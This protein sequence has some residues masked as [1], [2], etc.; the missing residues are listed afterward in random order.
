M[1]DENLNE[2]IH[3]IEELVHQTEALSDP[4]ARAL[5]VELLQAVLGFHAASLE[6]LIQ[7]IAEGG[8]PGRAILTAVATDDLTSSVLLLHNLHP[9]SLDVRVE[10]ALAKVRPSLRARGMAVSLLAIDGGTVRVSLEGGRSSIAA[11]V[12]ATIEE[13]IYSTAPDAAAV[14]VEGLEKPAASGFVPLASLL[15]S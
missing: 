10:R 6:R 2:R 12:Q 7:I 11:T 15:A 14:V 9:D 13:T 8:E 5:V 3:Q 4:K 1:P